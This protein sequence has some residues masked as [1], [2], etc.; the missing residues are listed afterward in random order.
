MPIT[1]RVHDVSRKPKTLGSP[2]GPG[3][4]TRRHRIL[5]E[6][7]GRAVAADRTAGRRE[8]PESTGVTPH[9][10]EVERAAAKVEHK[11]C[12]RSDIR[13]VGRGDRL[14]HEANVAKARELGGRPQTAGR[15]S[16]SVVTADE[17]DR[18]AERD[19]VRG[20]TGELLRAVPDMDEDESNEVLEAFR[21]AKHVR[22]SVEGVPE[23][24]LEGLEESAGSAGVGE[25]VC[26]EALVG[27]VGRG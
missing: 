1:E 8:D 12:P 24:G 10:A 26:L 4:Q 16:L 25:D 13:G 6:Q 22:A 9:Y 15:V 27:G 19:R 11:A 23:E 2:L 14:G 18:A 5:D 21:T 20:G 7:L 17:S 3:A